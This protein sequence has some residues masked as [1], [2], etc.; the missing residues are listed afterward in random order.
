MTRPPMN[1]KTMAEIWIPALLQDLTSGQAQVQVSADTVRQAIDLLEERYPGL[2]ARLIEDGRVRAS[3]A[4]VVD[5]EVSHLGLRQKLDE[6]SE[7][8]FL[9]AMSGG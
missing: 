5:G 6:N 4:V 1:G 7:V 8:H 9:P 2:R 3:I